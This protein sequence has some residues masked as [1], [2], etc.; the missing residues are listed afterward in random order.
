MKLKRFIRVG[1]FKTVQIF[2]HDSVLTISI[3]HADPLICS[4]ALGN[5]NYYEFSLAP[6]NPEK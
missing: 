3:K 6:Y 4:F 5:L 1:I 2:M